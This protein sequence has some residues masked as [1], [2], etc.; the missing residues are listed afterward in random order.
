ME[1]NKFIVAKDGK[2]GKM[3]LF[4][5][6][7]TEGF[8]LDRFLAEFDTL[9]NDDSV[10]EIEILINSL[11]G[12]TWKGFPIVTAISN[13][14]KPVTT[15]VD[16]V[17][18]S[19]A[20]LIFLAGTKRKVYDYSQ[21]MIHAAHYSDGSPADEKL[22]QVND[23]IFDLIKAVTKRGK[24][25]IKGWLSKDSWFTSK[26]ALIEG[27]ATE[28]IKTRLSLQNQFQSEVRSMVASA[29]SIEDINNLKSKYEQMENIYALLGLPAESD[30]K[31]VEAKIKEA[32][33]ALEIKTQ[34]ITNRES[35]IAE[36]E[37]S[38]KVYKDAEVAKHEAEIN[39]LVETAFSN[40][41]IN[42]EGKATWKTILTADFENGSKAIK[43]LAKTEKL[44]EMINTNQPQE[45]E[46]KL[47][48]IQ[49]MMVNPF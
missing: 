43:A 48:P 41:Q 22:N 18:A 8:T 11:G 16:T 42:S 19:M 32:Q 27:F 29:S 24:D 34:E 47:S 9:Q 33:T 6:I 12:S 4:N 35:K 2:V 39:A 44:S 46:V 5:E 38:L 13:S 45:I 23:N 7:D 30:A 28:I 49:S 15:V 26:Q 17:A 20:A 3:R 21:V 36:L 40:K 31:A 10:D 37:A 25:K 1:E 14:T